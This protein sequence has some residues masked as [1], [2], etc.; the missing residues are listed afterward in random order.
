MKG[1]SNTPPKWYVHPVNRWSYSLACSHAQ[2]SALESLHTRHYIHCDIKPANFVVRADGPQ[3]TV[4]LIDFGLAQLFRNPATYL[5]NPYSTGHEVV[6]TLPFMSVNGQ[7]G[8]AQSRRDDLESLVYTIVFAACGELPW[9]TISTSNQEAVL[10]QKKL[11][12]AEKL[13][14]GL[15]VHFCKFVHYVR[16]LDFDKKPDYQYLHS[17]LSQCSET[18]TNI[19]GETLQTP[20]RSPRDCTPVLSDRV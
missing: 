15:P 16:T 1:Y 9:T 13:C 3:S 5:H 7:R 18:E 8:C 17:I 11:I 4:S 20:S 10:Q 12:T 19:L 14:S 2:L 6:G